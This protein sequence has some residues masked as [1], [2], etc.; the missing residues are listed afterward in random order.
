MFDLVFSW[1]H[2][3]DFKMTPFLQ[4]FKNIVLFF[5]E[6]I[7]E[8]A[9]KKKLPTF[10]FFVRAFSDSLEGLYFPSIFEVW[11]FQCV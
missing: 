11:E 3:V 2:N 10:S 5:S 8:M 7:A 4:I 9:K 6:P 1:G